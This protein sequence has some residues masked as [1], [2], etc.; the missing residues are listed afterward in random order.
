[1]TEPQIHPVAALFPM[2][3]DDELADMAADISERGLIHPVVLDAEGR[4]LDGRNRYAACKL[5][6]VEPRFETYDGEDPGGYAL[7]VNVTRRNLRP[8][9]RY[10]V[11][12]QARRLAEAN[13]SKVGKRLLSQDRLGRPRHCRRL[14]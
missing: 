1:M 14:R 2:L 6:G 4:I 12:E 9:Q 10:L 7:S 11:A 3:T 13:G 5:A 8:G